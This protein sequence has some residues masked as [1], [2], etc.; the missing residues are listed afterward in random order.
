MHSKFRWSNTPCCLPPE[1]L[2]AL[3]EIV[4]RRISKNEGC[5]SSRHNCY[6]LVEC[7]F[8]WDIEKDRTKHKIT[9]FQTMSSFYNV[10]IKCVGQIKTKL[11]FV[12]LPLYLISV[13]SYLL[14]LLD[15]YTWSTPCEQPHS[16]RSNIK[17]NIIIPRS[18]E[19]VAVTVNVFICFDATSSIENYRSYLSHLI[20]CI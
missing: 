16:A 3:L 11:K 6:S 4:L 20:F 8:H 10:L 2:W 12:E 7:H 14:N 19:W 5:T 13:H 17:M 18:S 1:D 9:P 15:P